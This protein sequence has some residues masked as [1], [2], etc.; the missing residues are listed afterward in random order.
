[1]SVDGFVFLSDEKLPTV[2]QWQA[3]LDR[4]N[5]GIT[6]DV[7][8]DLRG[9]TGFFPVDHRGHESG[10]EWYYG[11]LADSFGATPPEG[12][13]GRGHVI[14]FVT[15]SDMR[16]LVCAMIAGAVL[17]DIADGLVFDEETGGTIDGNTAL[18][19]AKSLEDDI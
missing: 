2:Q 17:A 10:F 19:V 6:L 3:A 5:T 13:D 12:L 7:I 1:M 16:E 4:A 15:H 14:N 9:H 18:T 8:D 11:P